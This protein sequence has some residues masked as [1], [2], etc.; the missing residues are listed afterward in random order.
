MAERRVLEGLRMLITGASQG[1]GQALAEAA[2]NRGVR[3]L[4]VARSEAALAELQE[5]IRTPFES[6]AA[7]VTD[8][9]DR[10]RVIQAV[11]EK[12]GGLDLL[13]NNAGRGGFGLFSES[14][15]E[16]LRRIM[17][18]NFFAAVEM[19]RGCLPLL[20]AGWEPAIINVSDAR[21]RFGIKEQSEYAASKAAVEA[22]SS[23]LRAELSSQG[24]EV[25][26]IAPE[27]VRTR[28]SKNMLGGTAPEPETPLSPERVAQDILQAIERRRKRTVV[29]S[30]RSRVRRFVARLAPV[31]N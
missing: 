9:S 30:S 14:S 29:I 31:L 16:R 1:I 7:D 26:V 23:S 17:E 11:G 3:V 2:A 28:F 13:V 20:Q 25:L 12:L 4:A 27:P 15:S 24:I 8:P 10:R 19:T 22:F 5:R 6:L 18:V 21:A